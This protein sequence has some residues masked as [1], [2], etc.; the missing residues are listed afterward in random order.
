MI[1]VNGGSK[2]RRGLFSTLREG[3]VQKVV[4]LKCGESADLL[5]CHK[6][7]L[8]SIGGVLAGLGDSTTGTKAACGV[9]FL[10]R[11]D[12]IVSLKVCGLNDNRSGI[13]LL[14][15]ISLLQRTCWHRRDPL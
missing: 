14:S 9:L 11:H 12:E 13:R 6:G 15:K 10:F 1:G 5:A 4:E 2:S 8:T 7:Y 3:F